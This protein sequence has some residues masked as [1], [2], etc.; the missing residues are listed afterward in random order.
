LVLVAL[1]K[2]QALLAQMVQILYFHLLRLRVAEVV[3]LFLI[4]EE[5]LLLLAVLV[6]VVVGQIP[7]KLLA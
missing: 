5:M 2:V 1:V 4:P 6:A 3:A 7:E